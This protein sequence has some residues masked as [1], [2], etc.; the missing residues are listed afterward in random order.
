MSGELHT[1]HFMPALR[2]VG[3]VVELAWT[4]LWL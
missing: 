2:Y 4:Q 3:R 1:R